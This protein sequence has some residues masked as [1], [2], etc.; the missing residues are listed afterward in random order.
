M[1]FHRRW[2]VRRAWR[3]RA[4]LAA[5]LALA[6]WPGRALL[7]PA[8]LFLPL[9][10]LFYPPWREEE[11]AL[12]EIDEELGLVY[13]TALETPAGDQAAPRLR[14]EAEEAARRAR[15]PRF[16]WAELTLAAALWLAAGFLPPPGGK[17]PATSAASPGSTGAAQ[18]PAGG[19]ESQP[20]DHEG[21]REQATPPR[22][23]PAAPGQEE[24]SP[25]A[26]EEA[27][28]RGDVPN[29]EKGA[30]EPAATGAQP[31]PAATR[32]EKGAASSEPAPASEGSGEG[33]SAGTV[34]GEGASAPQAATPGE[35]AGEAGV[36]PLESAG[37][38]G[39]GRKS[40]G[41]RPP[42]AFAQP[43]AASEE[44]LPSPW[45]AGS[46]PQDVKRAAERYIQNNPLP[47]GAAEALRRYFE[48]ER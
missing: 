11:R 26:S 6:A 41:N 48:L 9:A 18:R 2:A 4:V 3:V 30:R 23:G 10:A 8:A 36:Q 42:K 28:Q 31:A 43:A 32:Q 47:P 13:R 34:G 25:A 39:R 5:L 12:A 7:G 22:S 29:A 24:A 14:R 16:P 27:P 37:G 45:P 19:K 33:Q 38:A 44:E 40:G 35:K 15:L 46:P 1:D 17:A 20:A 21:G